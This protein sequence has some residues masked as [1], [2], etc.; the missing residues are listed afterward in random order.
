MLAGCSPDNFP[1]EDKG[2]NSPVLPDT[3]DSENQD[4]DDDESG[5]GDEGGVNDDSDVTWGGWL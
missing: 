1:A 3:D 5:E 2:D 4:K